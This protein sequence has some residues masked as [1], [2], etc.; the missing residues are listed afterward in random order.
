MHEHAVL[1][2]VKLGYRGA[3]FNYSFVRVVGTNEKLDSLSWGSDFLV[4]VAFALASLVH[5]VFISFRDYFV[6]FCYKINILTINTLTVFYY[7][8]VKVE[9]QVKVM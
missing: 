8:T 6:L 5:V 3:L 4:A 1:R 9:C 2:A 7:S